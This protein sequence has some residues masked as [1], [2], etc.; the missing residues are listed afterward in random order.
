MKMEY[1]TSPETAE[2]CGPQSK[3]D[4]IEVE[5][6]ASSTLLE[7]FPRDDGHTAHPRNSGDGPRTPETWVG[8]ES[9]AMND[10]TNDTAQRSVEI[11]VAKY[12]TYLDDPALSETEKEEIVMAMWSIITAFIDLGFGVTPLNGTSGQEVCGQVAE[13][14]DAEGNSD[15]NGHKPEYAS[16]SEEFNAVAQA[17]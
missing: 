14:L 8:K 13:F 17:P 2:I 11:D 12:Q 10:N 15:S 7:A 6:S 16:L 3:Y 5:Q 9:A 1:I 4:N